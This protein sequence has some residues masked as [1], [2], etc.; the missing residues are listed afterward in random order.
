MVTIF[1]TSRTDG[2]SASAAPQEQQKRNPG[3]FSAPQLGR[4]VI[5]ASVTR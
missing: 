1:R 2:A 3:G 4:T 5:P